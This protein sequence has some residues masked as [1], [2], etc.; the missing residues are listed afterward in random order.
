MKAQNLGRP[1][2]ADGKTGGLWL[3]WNWTDQQSQM[4]SLGDFS[5]NAK[6]L[7][8]L[9]APWRSLMLWVADLALKLGAKSI[10][11]GGAMDSTVAENAKTSAAVTYVK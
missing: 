11:F 4:M 2:L 5:L 9:A 7:T 3:H 1:I 8:T 10:C 6:Y